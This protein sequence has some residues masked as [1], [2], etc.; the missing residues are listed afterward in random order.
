VLATVQRYDIVQAA[1][2]FSVD[3]GGYNTGDR[4]RLS[5]VFIGEV[6]DVKIFIGSRNVTLKF[7]GKSA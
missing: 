7:G 3:K 5:P 4:K 2:I 6:N 1:F